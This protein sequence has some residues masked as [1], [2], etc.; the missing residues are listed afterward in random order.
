MKTLSVLPCGVST[1]DL[2]FEAK[3]SI[4]DKRDFKSMREVR[5]YTPNKPV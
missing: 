2:D 4:Q 3:L 1:Q 5:S